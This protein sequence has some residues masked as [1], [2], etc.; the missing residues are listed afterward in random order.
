ME[1][2]LGVLTA[3][4]PDRPFGLVTEHYNRPR[5]LARCVI[6]THPN[7][8][9]AKVRPLIEQAI[10]KESL[11]R[12]AAHVG[13][14]HAQLHAYLKKGEQ[15][16]DKTLGKMQR[17]LE[18]DSGEEKRPASAVDQLMT[19]LVKNGSLQSTLR[20]LPVRKLLGLVYAAAIED[21]WPSA[22]V[23]WLDQLRNQ[24]LRTPRG[25]T[26]GHQAIP[27]QSSPGSATRA[28]PI[29]LAAEK[30]DVS[31]RLE[32]ADEAQRKLASGGRVQNPDADRHP[33]RKKKGSRD[34]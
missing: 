19:L 8:R 1:P 21:G 33:V 12:V 17:W 32:L 2:L 9:W 22:D 31:E 15:P 6:V 5:D 7:E 27:T 24:I 13:I 23:R 34:G 29:T 26:V 10:A 25:A 30:R 3:Y 20:R 16:S 18:G 11:R 4:L 28:T 14:S